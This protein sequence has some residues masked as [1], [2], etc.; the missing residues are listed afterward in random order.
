MEA[1]AES[2]EAGAESD[3]SRCGTQPK[4]QD[5]FFHVGPD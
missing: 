5:V 2:V 3:A 4:A 1:G